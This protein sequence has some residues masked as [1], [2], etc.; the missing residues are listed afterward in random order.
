MSLAV[1]CVLVIVAMVCGAQ[2]R[3]RAARALAG[4][5][6]A[7]V[8]AIGCGPVPAWLLDSLEQPFEHAPQLTW[9]PRNAIV[10]LGAG[11]FRVGQTVEPSLFSYPRMVQAAKLYEA[12]RKSDNDCK[13]FVSGG[14]ARH[15]GAPE[16]TVYARDLIALG[17]DRTD[18]LLEPESMN[19]WQNAQFSRALLAQYGPD[20]TVLVSS[21]IH[22]RRSLLYFAHFG[23]TPIP[24]RAD[25]LQATVSPLPLAYNFALTDFALHEWIG[26][27]RYHVYNALGWNPAR[28]QPGES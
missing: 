15:H 21:A 4:G 5:A 17:V 22:L 16:A 23:M 12:C 13:I 25:D 14:D 10:L 7:L 20:R 8:V 11:T 2:G 9:G 1:L 27:A 19:T 18:V 6:A 26:I 28:L 24:V 3:R